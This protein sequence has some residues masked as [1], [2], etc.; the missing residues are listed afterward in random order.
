MSTGKHAPNSGA[1]RISQAVSF[2]EHSGL[3]NTRLYL[4]AM[5]LALLAS[6]AVHATQPSAL[7]FGGYLL[8]N[9]LSFGITGLVYW[10]LRTWLEAGYLR[11]AGRISLLNLVLFGLILGAAKQLSTVVLVVALGLESSLL[12]ALMVRLI[13]PLLGVWTV[14]SLAA[15]QAG[16][17][18]YEKL[19]HELI[20]ER[21]RRGQADLTAN[22]TAH[23]QPLI[24]QIRLELPLEQTG[25]MSAQQFAALIRQIVEQ[26]I[27]PLSHEIWMREN[28]IIPG[29]RTGEL[30]ARAI[31]QAPYPIPII[32]MTYA[33]TTAPVVWSSAPEG[34]AGLWAAILCGGVGLGLWI[35]NVSKRFL[36]LSPRLSPLY[37]LAGTALG[38]SIGSVSAGLALGPLIGV[39]QALIWITSTWWLASI[40]LTAG[41]IDVA[42]KTHTEQLESLHKLVGNELAVDVNAAQR[43]LADRETANFLHSSV[44]NQLLSQALRVEREPEFDLGAEL[45][46]L[47]KLLEGD[48]PAAF[49]LAASLVELRADWAG[50]VDIEFELPRESDLAG[51]GALNPNLERLI[52]QLIAEAINNAHR[53]GR[54]RNIRVRLVGQQDVSLITVTD[55]GLGLNPKKKTP[56]LGTMLFS[57]A[58][59]W[60]LTNRLEGGAQLTLRVPH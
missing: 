4:W 24:D 42:R 14:L 7:V 16:R 26:Q 3:P 60:A 23:L 29:Y 58:G 30:A 56:G 48:D 21:A 43:R 55:D 37:L 9:L 35:S 22:R 49:D 13:T 2:I 10:A 40:A 6:V 59:E 46:A 36:E 31:L 27:R 57:S 32:L 45:V 50:L 19:R 15:L 12:S 1:R 53:H 38:V 52:Y 25:E 44:Q 18:H 11:S 28:A 20:A 41:V 33:I 54:A 8:A 47:L 34:T 39:N 17:E 51:S 5:P